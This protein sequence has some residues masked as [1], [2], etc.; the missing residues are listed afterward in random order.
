MSSPTTAEKTQSEFPDLVYTKLPSTEDHPLFAFKGFKPGLIILPKGHV[1]S[2]GLRAFGVPTAFDRDV[3]IPM[4]DSIK[5]Y[6]DIF[7]PAGSDV[8]KVPA[9]IPWSPYGKT[10]TGPQQYHT[11]APFNAGLSRGRTSGYQKFEAPDP[12]EWCERGYAIVNIDAR[13]AGMSEGNISFWGQQEAEDIYD[14]IE[15]LSKQPWCNGSVAMAGNSWLSIAQINFASRLSHP[16]LKALAPWESL[17]DPYRDTMTRGGMPYNRAFQKL[18]ISGFA[19]PNYAENLSEMLDKRPLYDS[20]WESK[21][22]K[23]ENIGDI[24]LYL[25]ASYSSGLHTKGS[26]HT[27]RT[28]KSSRKWLRVHHYQEWYDLYRPEITDELQRYFDRY[29]KGIENGWEHETPPVRLSLLGFEDSAVETVIER[30]EQ[31]YPLA[32][33]K[34]Q[35]YYL[36]AS[37]RKLVTEL[38]AAESTISHLGHDLHASSV[39]QPRQT[40]VA[41]LTYCS[42]TLLST[43]IRGQKLLAILKSDSGCPVPRKTIWMSLFKSESSHARVSCSLS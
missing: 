37:I 16:A 20:F 41:E 21:R 1:L 13:G 11:M 17:T 9:I 27:F 10:G 19:G 29:C 2:E 31:E 26:F 40:L 12:A 33:Q 35:L 42:R 38:P 8:A 39:R 22:I 30:P 6:A 4:R 25:L 23:T 43:L 15:W 3:A 5:L 36:D 24:P 14:T 7:R 32:R 34:L 28:A 18:I